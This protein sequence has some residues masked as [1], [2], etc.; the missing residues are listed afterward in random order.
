MDADAVASAAGR[1]DDSGVLATLPTVGS[2][3]LAGVGLF[4]MINWLL[5]FRGPHLASLAPLTAG[6][7]LLF[8]WAT[9]PEHA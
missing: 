7:C 2:S 4:G 3:V 9:G 5:T 8:G 1:T 6:A